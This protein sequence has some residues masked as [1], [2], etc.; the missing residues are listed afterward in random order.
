MKSKAIR[1]VGCSKEIES[2]RQTKP[3]LVE[4]THATSVASGKPAST[5]AQ[6]HDDACPC[7]ERKG[8]ALVPESTLIGRLEMEDASRI[9]QEEGIAF[10][11][12]TIY[13]LLAR[14]Q[15]DESWDRR[16]LVAGLQAWAARFIEEFKLDVKQIALCVDP[17]P[18]NRYGHFRQGH[19]GFGL[20]G[21]IAINARYLT[22]ELWEILGTLLHELL[23]AWQE[24]HGTP[25]KRNHHNAEFQA[26]AR[27]LG[28]IVD[29]CGL[30]GYTASSPFKALL[31]EC[32]VRA[33]AHEVVAPKAR[34]RGESKM[35]KWTCGCG[36]NVRVAIADFRARCLKC[37]RE[38]KREDTDQ[39]TASQK[40]ATTSSDAA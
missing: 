19:N 6:P 7:V 25:S 26:K 11:T 37:Q 34:P 27:E 1:P 33:P 13:G 35:K 5:E 4:S 30:T 38:F 39:V 3:F 18:C 10:A 21:E 17:L 22:R 28:L 15:R 8:D 24:E 12:Q 9:A 31:R 36:T 40:D 23:H 2:I 20:R 29:R 16:E 14:H 32:G